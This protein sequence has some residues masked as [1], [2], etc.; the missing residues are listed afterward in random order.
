MDILLRDAA[1]TTAIFGFFAS[2]WF[3]WAQ[4]RPPAGP[5]TWWLGGGSAAGLLLAVAGG[6]LSWL[7][8]D[9]GSVLGGD[10]AMALYLVILAVEF[11]AALLGVLVLLALGRREYF[12]PWICLVVGVHFF[13]MAPVLDNVLLYPLAVWLTLWPFLAVR[14]ADR[15]DL[16][17]SFTT[18]VGAGPALLL[19]ALPA[20]AAVA[21]AL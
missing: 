7:H 3:G 9:T 19:T 10:G 18:G 17:Y 20:A 21:A 8:W 16:A 12:A 2:A 14:W 11:G 6:V 4:E 1:M 15:R 13:P 5:A